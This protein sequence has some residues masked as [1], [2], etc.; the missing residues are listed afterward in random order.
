MHV[1]FSSNRNPAL[2]DCCFTELSFLEC[3]ACA[4]NNQSEKVFNAPKWI[5]QQRISQTKQNMLPDKQHLQ[6][7][8]FVFD[9]MLCNGDTKDM[10]FFLLQFTSINRIELIEFGIWKAFPF[11]IKYLF[12]MEQKVVSLYSQCQLNTCYRVFLKK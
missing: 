11:R 4:H 10:L 5:H 1:F 3:D 12:D 8:H 6:I 2:D 9:F 7:F